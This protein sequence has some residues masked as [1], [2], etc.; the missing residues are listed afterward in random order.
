MK[1]PIT[2][3]EELE[4]AS[5]KRPEFW[6]PSLT[7]LIAHMEHI[8]SRWD[9]AEN[10]ISECED[11]KD[12]RLPIAERAINDFKEAAEVLYDKL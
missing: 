4:M 12:P 8:E 9:E 2:L 11:D 10:F 1:K 6:R 5:D 7:A 3:E